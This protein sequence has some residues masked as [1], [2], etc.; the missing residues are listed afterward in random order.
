MRVISRGWSGRVTMRTWPFRIADS[1]QH[2]VGSLSM[3]EYVV[4]N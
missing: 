3:R 4:P 1:T 2:T